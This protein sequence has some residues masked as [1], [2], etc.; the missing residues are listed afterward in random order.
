MTMR[1]ENKT[2]IPRIPGK[3]GE[4]KYAYTLKAVKPRTR[5]YL[6]SSTF[7]SGGAF[8]SCPPLAYHTYVLVPLPGLLKSE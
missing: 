8:Y 2:G 1:D 3:T 6:G 4:K 7:K 5:T